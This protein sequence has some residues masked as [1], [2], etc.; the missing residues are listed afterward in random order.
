MSKPFLPAELIAIVLNY[1]P[2]PDLLRAARVSRKVHEMVYDDTRWIQKLK[3]LGVW[4]EAE[5]RRR[6]EEAQKR[7]LEV[8]RAREADEAR[9][10]GARLAGSVNG[11]AGGGVPRA[12][13]VTLFDV[14]VEEDKIRRSVEQVQSQV[15][16]LSSQ[17][18][19]SVH[20]SAAS[21]DHDAA[22]HVL[23]QARSIRGRA[24]H[25]FSIIYAALA[26][27][28]LNLVRSK[29]H[30][31]AIV[32]KTY[33]D[34]EHQAQI[35]ASL[36]QFARCDSAN[37]WQDR[38]QKVE[39]VMGVFENAVLREFEQGC[40]AGD[41]EGRM[42]RYAHVLVRLNGGAAAI[43]SFIS[44]HPIMSRRLVVGM[45]MDCVEDV[46]PGHVDLGPA[47][48]FFENL[49][50]KVIEQAGV[51]DRVFPES[52]D[53][54]TPFLERLCEQIIN[55]YL[56]TLF[57]EARGKGIET[58]VKAIAGTLEQALRFVA[59]LQPTRA[60]PPDFLDLVKGMILP[61]YE[62]RMDRYLGDE[63]T[64]FLDK[65]D[66]EVSHWEKDFSDS[67]ASKESFFLSN[68]TRQAAKRDFLSSFRKVVMLPVTV[69]PA[70]NTAAKPLPNKPLV[71]RIPNMGR[72][73]SPSLNGTSTPPRP[74]TPASQQEAPVT[75]LAA[76]AAIMNSRLEGIK[77]LFSIEVAL[78]LTHMAKAS[79]E[80][81]ALMT[82]LGG[83]YGDEAKVKC[84]AVFVALL[85]VLGD[86][87][88]KIGFDRAVGHLS[89]YDPREVREIRA[90]NSTET[91]GERSVGVEPLVTFL[92]LVNVG[93]LIQQMI[94]VFFTQEMLSTRLVD[95]DDFLNPAIKEKKRFE[96]MLDERVAAGL[97]RGIDVLMSEIEYICAT[98]QQ[99]TDFNP[100]L[101]TTNGNNTHTS[102]SQ[103][104]VLDIGPTPTAL[105]IVETV[106]S[107]TSML[108]GS[109]DKNTLDVFV[110][111]IGLRLFAVLCKHFKRQ[112][113]SV[114]GAI[115]FISDINHYAAF[116]STLKQKA[117]LPYFQ[118]LREMA[119]IYLVEI[120]P[121][122]ALFGNQGKGTG[123]GKGGTRGSLVWGGGGKTQAQARELAAIV[124]DA[125]R[126][127]GVLTSEEVYEFAERRA[128]WF[129]VKGDVER[130]LYGAGCC[131][132]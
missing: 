111:E 71:G 19:S 97:N 119:Q 2:V 47:Q 34:P 106:S 52:V 87:H 59:S 22:L 61:F 131:V 33:R 100:G 35:L 27:L 66:S 1:L 41:V 76:K 24:R 107:H 18:T 15:G 126:Y 70:F 121:P 67:E 3:L 85:H 64:L 10:T 4:S 21:E 63:L 37:G 8:Q 117:L 45:P 30:S 46:A 57:Q 36:K 115:V 102:P 16:E 72:P 110:T 11:I 88:I 48:N 93:D 116:V 14:G 130:A 68:L 75:E 79:I 101:T 17:T 86:R 13:N 122:A 81:L 120:T 125:E 42:H 109:T 89:N 44:H 6:V 82:Q 31:D 84:N 53:V 128:D 74:S 62:R 43:D 26:P 77:S 65:S 5:A 91:N 112:R 28:Y 54:L 29:R 95:S 25:E 69:L 55:E 23:A 123:K 40:D 94:D 92:E 103:V 73:A 90:R 78:N 105:Q 127:R 32:F 9:R 124:A 38:E 39:S 114:D 50:N 108:G 56:L 80:R 49:A 129:L 104:Q 113:I 83:R 58:W 7:R 60:S 98:T 96:Q 20:P 118:A 12:G 51:I 132:M 99:P